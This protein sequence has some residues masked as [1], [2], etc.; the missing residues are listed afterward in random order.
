MTLS[1][2]YLEEVGST[3]PQTRLI[4]HQHEADGQHLAARAHHLAD[5]RPQFAKALGRALFGSLL[6]NHCCLNYC[7]GC[8]ARPTG[9]QILM[10]TLYSGTS[11]FAYP[12]W[13]PEFYPEK[14]PSKKFLS[15]YAT[16]LNA[17]EVNYTFRRLPS[18]ST[19]ENWV[20]DTRR[21]LR[22]SAEGAHAHHAHFEAEAIGVHRG[23]LSRHRSA[24][25]RAAAGAGAVSAAARAQMRRGAFV[26]IFSRRCRAISAA[27]SS[28]ATRPG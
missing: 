23:L 11:G 21:R 7:M 10:P 9:C 14:L 16:R 8:A 28:S 15:Y 12:S 3:S 22:V 1:I 20:N 26:R 17:V 25:D 18:A 24:A 4:D 19:L 13:K 6:R 5:V 27:R 2:R